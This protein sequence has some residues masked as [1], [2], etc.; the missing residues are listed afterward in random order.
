[1]VAYVS[2]GGITNI[3]IKLQ[4]YTVRTVPQL[5]TTNIKYKD[6]TVELNISFRKDIK[7]ITAVIIYKKITCISNTHNLS[8]LFTYN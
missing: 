8:E 6:L 2:S 4:I 1:M 7:I 3:I 5:L